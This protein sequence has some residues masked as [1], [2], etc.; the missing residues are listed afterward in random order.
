[1]AWRAAARPVTRLQG[2]VLGGLT[3]AGDKARRW[4][5]IDSVAVFE[6]TE[7]GTTV[8]GSGLLEYWPFGPHAPSG[9][10]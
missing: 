6:C 7:D 10:D 3:R 5:M 9:L 1:V 8:I 4:G 2:P